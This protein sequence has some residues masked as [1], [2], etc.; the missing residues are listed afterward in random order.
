MD[1]RIARISL[2]AAL[3]LTLVSASFAAASDKAPKAKETPKAEAAKPE[4]Q[5]Q[6]MMAAMM[7]MAMPGPMHELLKP[8]VGA[9]KTT[10]RSWMAPGEPILSEG[11]CENTWIMGNR[12]M[13]S[14][15]KGDFDGKPF[16]GMGL[17]GYD[18]QQKEFVS[19][20]CDNMGTGLMMSDGTADASG[21]VFTLMSKMPDPVTRKPMD[22]KMITKVIDENQH[23]M[24]M[25][26]MKDGKEH[27]DMEI[28]Y[29]RMK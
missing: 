23:T 8:M 17:M 14:T 20:W 5:H 13:Q 27:L 24:S 25:I 4:A 1:R 22:L 16:E 9:W 21:K 29:T 2:S 26:S 10:S 12:Y 15:H 18:N 7:K 3:A 19:V 28:T 6:E 11:T